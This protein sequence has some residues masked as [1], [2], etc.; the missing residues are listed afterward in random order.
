MGKDVARVLEC[1]GTDF[2][3]DVIPHNTLM[4]LLWRPFGHL[5][6]LFLL[7]MQSPRT[8]LRLTDLL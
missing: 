2:V 4:D 7:F 3:G 5:G 1:R 8:P 6:F